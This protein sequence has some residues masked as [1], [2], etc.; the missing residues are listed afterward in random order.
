MEA[1]CVCAGMETRREENSTKRDTCFP[2]GG[3]GCLSKDVIKSREAQS[4]KKTVPGRGKPS[5]RTPGQARAWPVPAT[6][7]NQGWEGE[8]EPGPSAWLVKLDLLLQVSGTLW[9]RSLLET[10]FWVLCK[11]EAPE[12]QGRKRPL[13]M[14]L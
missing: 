8:Q 10:P 4:Y 2:K 11:N 5:A 3:Q 6:R 9:T 1:L 14:C 12:Y 7:L 13:R